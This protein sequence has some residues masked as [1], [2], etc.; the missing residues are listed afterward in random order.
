MIA[1]CEFLMPSCCSARNK[2]GNVK[3]GRPSPPK[4]RPPNCRN[5]RRDRPSQK[6]L[7]APESVNMAVSLGKP[8]G[9]QPAAAPQVTVA[10]GMGARGRWEFGRTPLSSFAPRK[11]AHSWSERRQWVMLSKISAVE[12]LTWFEPGFHGIVGN[13]SA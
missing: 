9:T 10:D 4:A 3:F 1:L 11:N 2:L 5:E 7:L 13:V 6:R 8:A 12:I